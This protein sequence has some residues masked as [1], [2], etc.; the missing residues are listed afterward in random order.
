MKKNDTYFLVAMCLL[1][2]I[3]WSAF[4]FPPSLTKLAV[5]VMIIWTAS[6]FFSALI[7]TWLIQRYFNLNKFYLVSILISGWLL[8]PILLNHI[9]YKIPLKTMSTD[10]F[11]IFGLWIIFVFL[12]F[13]LA[14]LQEKIFHSKKTRL[15]ILAV[16]G[17]C[18]PVNYFLSNSFVYDHGNLNQPFNRVEEYSEVEW[19]GHK[20]AVIGIDGADWNVILPLIEK[21]LLPNIA[22]LM[23]KGIS[24]NCV[25]DLQYESPMLWTS[26][27]T[28]LTPRRHGITDWRHSFSYNRKARSL[29]NILNGY[30]LK[31]WISNIPGTYPMEQVEHGGVSG[32]PL[33]TT[34]G[35]VSGWVVTNRE[36][37]KTIYDAL[38]H[39]AS[40]KTAPIIPIPAA[41]ETARGGVRTVAIPLQFDDEY[42]NAFSSATFA[43]RFNLPNY[44]FE[45]VLKN[46][47][48]WFYNDLEIT[49]RLNQNTQNSQNAVEFKI[50][51]FNQLK[52]LVLYENNWSAFLPIRLGKNT[53][54]F[55]IFLAQ[56]NSG[57]IE[58]YV[59]PIFKHIDQLEAVYPLQL[60]ENSLPD[61]YLVEGIGFN[62]SAIYPFRYQQLQQ[63]NMSI[64]KNHHAVAEKLIK[65]K[66]WEFFVS[67]YTIFDRAQHI[68]WPLHEPEQ[69]A[70]APAYNVARVK[71][72]DLVDSTLIAIDMRLGRLLSRCDDST[73]VVITSDH[74]FRAKPA[75]EES[76]DLG[77]HRD[78][79]IF[80]IA[81]PGI[82]KSGQFIA[83]ISMYEIL[84]TILYG[85]GLPVADDFDGDVLKEVFLDEFVENNPTKNI[86]SYNTN[87]TI[88][89][90]TK[91]DQ[92]VEEQLKSLGYLK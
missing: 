62:T 91:I 66:P 23:K 40:K 17:L 61:P 74:G 81:G 26:I 51:L 84:P 35:N 54:Y 60:K 72:G 30:G 67:I 33:P 44:F 78:K 5:L 11:L 13:F 85:M 71:H 14:R 90:E 6:Q 34:L 18:F 55:A 22:S 86:R 50:D 52:T 38:L 15:L 28:G 19:N 47:F 8:Y 53:G 31:G 16:F 42:L 48:R 89:K 2:G 3:F 41:E 4:Y 69:Y 68:F 73:I 12:G 49:F 25:T 58:F 77:D 65:S 63:H 43:T 79:G 36:A 32:F 59:S 39:R 92:N 83:N 75:T 7:V 37:T 21:G 87:Q 70:N 56:A 64:L 46:I 20:I 57:E 88:Y 29:W 76:L 10:L 27:F 45:K 24:A 9:D 1:V 80:I 82:K